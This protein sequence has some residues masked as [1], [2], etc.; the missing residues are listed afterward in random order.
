MKRILLLSI[1]SLLSTSILLSQEVKE[2]YIECQT[3]GEYTKIR[4][5]VLNSWGYKHSSGE[6]VVPLGKYVSV[7]EIDDEGMIIARK[8]NKTGIIN[9]ADE[10][11]VPFVYD[12]INPFSMG[13]AAVSNNGKKGFINRRGEVVIPLQYNISYT[14]F[15]GPGLAIVKKGK[16]GVIDMQNNVIIPFKYSSISWSGNQNNFIVKKGGRWA[17]FSFDCVQLS[18]FYY[19][20]EVTQASHSRVFTDAKNLPTLVHNKE[21]GKIVNAYIDSTHHQIVPYGVY[22]FAMPFSLGRK[23]I[24]RKDNRYGIID[25]YGTLVLPLAYDNI[26]RIWGLANKVFV[27]QKGDEITIFDTDLN[28][29]PLEKIVEYSISGD[30]IIVTGV[31]GKKGLFSLISAEFTVP[32]I[33]DDLKRIGSMHTLD[34]YIAKKNGLWG[35]IS[36]DNRVLFPFEYKHIISSNFGY[37]CVDVHNKARFLNE[38]GDVIIPPEY[39]YIQETEYGWNCPHLGSYIVMKDGKSGTVNWNNEVVIPIIYDA[40]SGFIE[41]FPDAHFV[42]NENKIGL[43]SRSGEIIVPIE[44]SNVYIPRLGVGIIVV[45]KDGKFGVLSSINGDVIMPCNYEKIISYIPSRF[46]YGENKEDKLFVWENGLLNYYSLKGKLIQKNVP[47]A[48]FM[49]KYG[50]MLKY[51]DPSEEYEYK[52][53]NRYVKF[54]QSE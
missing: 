42:K 3:S 48:Q 26:E 8:G 24:V 36:N 15:Y 17:S 19:Y 33:Y 23:A 51:Q 1:L 44:Y 5:R 10:I 41:S 16:Y 7:Y 25:E 43:M 4:S 45:G 47:E 37:V 30:E 6:I 9:I 11:L 32:M 50:F 18:D 46:H 13:L 52:W 29:L 40:L 49:E 31:N 14:G 54:W 27:T 22:D 12:N 39:D 28:A 35:R 20:D 21:Q 53:C 34:A 2:E 38:K